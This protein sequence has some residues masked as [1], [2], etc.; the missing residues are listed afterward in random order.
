L[1]DCGC[2]KRHVITEFGRNSCPTCRVWSWLNAGGCCRV[3]EE[4]R[5]DPSTRL[6][7]KVSLMKMI[8]HQYYLNIEAQNAKFPRSIYLSQ[9]FGNTR[10]SGKGY[11]CHVIPPARRVV[12]GGP[13]M[14]PRSVERK[15][16]LNIWMIAECPLQNIAHLLTCA[17]GIVRRCYERRIQVRQ[18]SWS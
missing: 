12:M 17:E 3:A 4:G 15:L 6:Q 10:G 14:W 1:K 9:S 16:F 7:L 18:R 2:R 8:L 11:L 13:G 5:H